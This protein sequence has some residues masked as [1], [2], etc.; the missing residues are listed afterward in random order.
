MD[1]MENERGKK[2][3]ALSPAF[4]PSVTIRDCGRKRGFA[5][6]YEQKCV[7]WFFGIFFF[8]KLWSVSFQRSL[9]QS[10]SNQ[11]KAWKRHYIIAKDKKASQCWGLV[12]EASLWPHPS[13]DL[14]RTLC[15]SGPLW[16]IASARFQQTIPAFPSPASG[17]WV[18]W[19]LSHV[20]AGIH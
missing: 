13:Q 5:V 8:L 1:N 20:W 18:F 4:P 10:G 9:Q 19:S 16:K 17:L 15:S 14:W 11:L 12:A 3:K 7:V 2:K 6:L